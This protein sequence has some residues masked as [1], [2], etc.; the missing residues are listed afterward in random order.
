M[1]CKGEKNLIFQEK[2]NGTTDTFSFGKVVVVS[3]VV[4]LSRD[5]CVAEQ[6]LQPDYMMH[7][8]PPPPRERAWCLMGKAVQPQTQ[9]REVTEY[10][11]PHGAPCP[12]HTCRVWAEIGAEFKSFYVNQNFLLE[13][14]YF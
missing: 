12:V 10:I 2:E 5:P 11:Q 6:A 7:H 9:P 14:Q 4:P 13:N 8:F 3:A 1:F